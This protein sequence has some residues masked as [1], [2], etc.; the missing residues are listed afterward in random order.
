[1]SLAPGERVSRWMTPDGQRRRERLLTLGLKG[2]WREVLRGFPGS[3]ELGDNL[4]DLRG[5]DLSGYQLPGAELVQARLEGAT[6][7]EADLSGASLEL[8]TLSGA[9]LRWTALDGASLRA[10][11]ALETRW[12]DASLEGAVL[13]AANLTGGSFRRAWLRGAHLNAATLKRA[14]LRLANLEEADLRF[15]DLE[16][17]CV[18][19]VRRGRPRTYVSGLAE[20]GERQ[21]FPTFRDALELPLHE[22]RTL[23]RRNWALLHVEAGLEASPEPARELIALLR[24]GYW[25]CHLVA[26]TALVLGG[27]N[28]HT[29]PALWRRIDG[30]SQVHPQLV[31]AALLVDP[32]FERNATLRLSGALPPPALISLA[33]ALE[34]LTG[35][36]WP[37]PSLTPEL[38]RGPRNNCHRWLRG[39]RQ[40]VEPRLQAAWPLL[41]E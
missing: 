17:A 32:D 4:G 8:A 38:L 22:L 7:D 29:L 35:A 5:I 33:W 27:A 19:C 41:L 13:T 34:M 25:Q 31:V 11:V 23:E 36:P 28:E 10:C 9:S 20:L 2:A 14:D 39:L 40:H 16:D 30:N 6:L 15:C 21:G 37:L 18:A 3:A 24:E 1:M 12:D 26:A